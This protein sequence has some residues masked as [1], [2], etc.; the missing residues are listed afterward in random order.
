MSIKFLP[1]FSNQNAILAYIFRNG[2]FFITTH[3]NFF[4]C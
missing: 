4:Y 3:K 2:T 1:N